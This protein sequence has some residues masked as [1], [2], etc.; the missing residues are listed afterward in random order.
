[1]SEPGIVLPRAA[2]A[3]QATPLPAILRK[4]KFFRQNNLAGYGFLAPWLIG[5]F[6]FALIP[7]LISLALAFTDFDVLSGNGKFIGLQNFQRMFFQ[8]P[9]YWKSV[10]ATIKF[11]GISVPFRLM[12]ALGVAMLLNTKHRGVHWYRAVYYL[13]SLIGGSVAIAVM[14]RQVFGYDGLVNAILAGLGIPGTNWLGNPQ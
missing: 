4:R 7:I 11:V 2:A 5:F 9:R 14:W 1:M 8:D 3:E 10:S 13:P 6:L 12:F